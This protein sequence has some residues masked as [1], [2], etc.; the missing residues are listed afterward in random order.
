M[1]QQSSEGEIPINSTDPPTDGR[2]APQ[3]ATPIAETKKGEDN[4]IIGLVVYFA[5]VLFGFTV[6]VMSLNYKSAKEWPSVE[7][8]DTSWQL[9]R[10]YRDSRELKGGGQS[11]FPRGSIVAEF[12]GR[13]L[14]LR[15]A[16]ETKWQLLGTVPENPPEDGAPQPRFS[17]MMRRGDF[18]KQTRY[19]EITFLEDGDR[20]TVLEMVPA[21]SLVEEVPRWSLTTPW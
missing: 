6:F 21:G 12:R 14:Y 4:G 5:A 2:E 8:T 18:D 9:T 15:R 1:S 19:L 11:D 17:C 16:F 20:W 13:D 3:N 7:V 10:G